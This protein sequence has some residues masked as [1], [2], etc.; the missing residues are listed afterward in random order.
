VAE[1]PRSPA[2]KLLRRRLAAATPLGRAGSA[3]PPLRG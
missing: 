1:L 2:G 3:A